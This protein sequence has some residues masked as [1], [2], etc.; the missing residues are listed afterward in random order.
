MVIK[1]LYS[2][3][4]QHQMQYIVYIRVG[5]VY[6]GS[7][8]RLPEFTISHVLQ[9]FMINYIICMYILYIYHIGKILDSVKY[10]KVVLE[11]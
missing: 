6:N 7:T 1:L 10:T 5:P 3:L 9:H 8:K 2:C 4:A 11:F